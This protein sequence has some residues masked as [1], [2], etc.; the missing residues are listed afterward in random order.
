MSGL[1]ARVNMTVSQETSAGKFKRARRR[2]VLR[3]TQ[4]LTIFKL[5]GIQLIT[6]RSTK[7]LCTL[8]VSTANLDLHSKL[9]IWLNVPVLILLVHQGTKILKE[10][11]QKNI[12]RIIKNLMKKL[13]NVPQTVR[14][15]ATT[16]RTRS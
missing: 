1:S 14:L 4:P 12:F 10:S 7:N 16:Q 11:P 13:L 2:C 15:T 5:F 9:V 6:Q 3:K 8:T